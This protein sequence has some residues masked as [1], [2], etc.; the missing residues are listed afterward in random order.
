ME[1][2]D[3]GCPKIVVDERVAS[4]VPLKDG[5]T[6]P[7]TGGVSVLDKESH[8]SVT[9]PSPSNFL[10]GPILPNHLVV[11][12]PLKEASHTLKAPSA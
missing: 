1:A 3:A 12:L 9:L 11:E 7:T 5:E 6:N 10:A 4:A 2:A 8:C